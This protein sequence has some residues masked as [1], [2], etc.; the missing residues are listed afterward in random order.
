[1]DCV[2]NVQMIKSKLIFFKSDLMKTIIIIIKYFK[3]T[4]IERR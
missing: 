3:K 1:M 2:I 4:K